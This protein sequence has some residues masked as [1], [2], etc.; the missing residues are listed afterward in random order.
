MGRENMWWIGVN[1]TEKEVFQI[2]MDK[3]RSYRKSK[4]Q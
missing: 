2:N 3:N 4:G 1:P